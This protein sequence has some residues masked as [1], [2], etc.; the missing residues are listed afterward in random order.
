[1]PAKPLTREL[2]QRTREL[3]QRTLDALRE[4]GSQQKASAALGISRAT[5]QS[6]IVRARAILQ[7]PDVTAY[8][9]PPSPRL[10][11]TADEAWTLLDG[12]IGRKRTPFK[13]PQKWQAKQE[14]RYVIA[15]DFHAPFQDNEAV[16]ELIA[17]ESAFADTLII[18]GDLMD[19]YSISR[20]IKYEHIPIE[21]EIAGAD[22]LLTQLAQHFKD[23][24][25]IEG[26]HDTQRFEKQLR[27]LL[28]P[29]MMHCIELLTG[30]NLSILQ[31]LAKRHS[32]VR[33]APQQAG[34][35]KL[36]WLTQVGD[37]L[38]S[39]AE[40]F[41]S[42]P[43]SALRKIEEGMA[44]FEQVYNLQPWRV[45]VQ[46]HTH[47]YSMIPW[48]SDKLLCEGGAMCL[49]HGY[50]LTARMGGRPQRI[51]Y[52][53]LTQREGKTDLN[54]VKFHWLNAEKRVA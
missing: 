43:G 38:V 26:N 19:F 23:V 32:N 37:L 2:A 24:L 44:D 29:E 36:G 42:V 17:R 11:V 52:T 51:G 30:G 50:Q 46:A 1:M 3:A 10:P 4:H 9:P 22:A 34:H 20:F 33:F 40:K 18:S 13:H 16:G 28:T 54:S 39:H 47:A 12:W 21:Q 7:V 41:S 53:T 45:L 8:T 14:L 31:M 48:H 15:G 25:I 49:T 35:Y 27:T 5:L 6:R